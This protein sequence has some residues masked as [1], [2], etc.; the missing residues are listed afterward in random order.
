MRSFLKH[1]SRLLS[2]YDIMELFGRV[3]FKIQRWDIEVNG[4]KVTGLYSINRNVLAEFITSTL[5]VLRLETM[6][7]TNASLQC[8]STSKSINFVLTIEMSQPPPKNQKLKKAGNLDLF[9]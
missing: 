4:F 1:S 2:I 8:S 3:Y 7:Q 9:V 5:T 6:R